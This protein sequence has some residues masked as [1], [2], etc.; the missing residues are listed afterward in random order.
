GTATTPLRA[1]TNIL[2]IQGLNSSSNDNPFLILPELSATTFLAE[3]P[4]PLYFTSPTPGA[5]NSGGATTPGPVIRDATHSPNVPLDVE[6]LLVTA[7]VLPSFYAVSNVTLRYRIMYGAEVSV[8][9]L[10]DGA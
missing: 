1:A 2:P 6:D 5:P 4:L 9:I 3:S 7:R 8:P 10:D